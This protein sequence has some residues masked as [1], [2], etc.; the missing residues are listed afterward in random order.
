M[1]QIPTKGDLQKDK[2]A[3]QE[4]DRKARIPGEVKSFTDDIVAA[5]GRGE[6]YLPVRTKM[7]E[8]EAQQQIKDDFRAK[9]WIV[10]FRPARTG[11]SITWR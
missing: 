1:S 2:A 10:E 9:G 6:N 7:P 4:S 5:M 3:Q 11:G 8:P